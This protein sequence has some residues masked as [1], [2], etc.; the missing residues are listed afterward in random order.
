MRAATRLL[1]ALPL[2][3]GVS[4]AAFAQTD[5]LTIKKIACAPDRLTRCKSAGVECETKDA[6]PGDKARPLVIDFESKKVAMRRDGEDRPFGLVLA[7]KVEGDVRNVV[8]GRGDKPDAQDTLTFT[9][10]KD[11]KMDGTRNDGRN[12]METT[13][14]PAG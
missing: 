2:T 7:D 8:I 14:V 4:A 5:F 11:G 6:S 12:K 3:I 9:L 13:C 10:R 1:F